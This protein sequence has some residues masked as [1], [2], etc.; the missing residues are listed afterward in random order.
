VID[1]KHG[2]TAQTTGHTWDGD[3]QEFNNPIPRWWL[4]AFNATVLFAVVY[5]VLY[6]AWPVGKDFTK[7]VSSITYVSGG[8]EKTT[9]WNTRAELARQMQDSEASGARAELLTRVAQMDYDTLLADPEVMSFTR[10]VG[11]RLFADNCAPCHGPGG[12]GVVGR[13]P[14]LADDDWLWGGGF[15]DIQQ[16]ITGG[17]RGFMPAF[18]RTFDAR[19]LD[20]VASYVLSLSGHTVDPQAEARGEALFNGQGGGCHYCHTQ[21]GTGLPSQGAANLTDAIWAKA[22]VPAQPDLAGKKAVV[23]DLIRK[24]VQG[25]VMPAWSGRLDE[26]EI[27]VL[28]VFVH[29]LGGGI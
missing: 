9:H 11:K 6:P 7:G 20:D 15:E 5:W 23:K 17:R 25:S 16:T 19:Q 24:G 10:A 28:T 27:K 2:H 22:D 21:Q 3:L 12:G 4:W 18:E 13:F 8:E 29:E 14:N 26:A 1:S